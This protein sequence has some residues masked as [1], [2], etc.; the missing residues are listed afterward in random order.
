VEQ[1]TQKLIYRVLPAWLSRVLRREPFQKEGHGGRRTPRQVPGT[2]R[3]LVL[4]VVRVAVGQCTS[5]N[6][7]AARDGWPSYHKRY[8]KLAE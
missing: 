2:G 8:R 3:W 1:S 4:L 6:A 7:A 5:S